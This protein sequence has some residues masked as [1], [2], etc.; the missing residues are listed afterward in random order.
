MNSKL[1]IDD[2]ISHDND[3]KE[4]IM[5]SFPNVCT[6]CS[7]ILSS[8]CIVALGSVGAAQPLIILEKILYVV[9][10]LVKVFHAKISIHH[11]L[12]TYFLLS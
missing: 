1:N 9:A 3:Q 12:K 4:V 8:L 7:N 2:L 5:A 11:D 10:V 6:G